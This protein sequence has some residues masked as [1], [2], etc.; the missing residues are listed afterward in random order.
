MLR[1]LTWLKVLGSFRPVDLKSAINILVS[2]IIDVALYPLYNQNMINVLG[3]MYFLKELGLYFYVR[4][5]TEDLY[6]I[7]PGRE[8]KIEHFI[9]RA[10]PE[11]GYFVD[12]GANIG[13]YTCL[14]GKV[15]N[16]AKVISV[17]PL[18][19]TFRVLKLNCHLN[20]IKAITI[21]KALWSKATKLS[22]CI[23]KV[24]GILFY[25]LSRAG[26]KDI[27]T[28][29]SSIEIAATT[30]DSV[31]E[32]YPFPRVDLIKID[33]EGSEYEML[34]GAKRTI[35]KT[36]YLYIECRKGLEA[37][38][39]NYLKKYGFVFARWEVPH[40]VHLFCVNVQV[41]NLK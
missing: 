15:K 19:D 6:Y 7:I 2:S 37:L 30:L 12:V 1:A 13:Y 27:N 25:G 39:K 17:E 40:A 28:C 31:L 18:P 33:A 41:T 22:F 10:V 23:P 32:I 14:I 21:N 35:R 38:I 24:K 26:S 34:L 36:R 11:G 9:L 5:R 20:H 8:G 16:N 4:P 3:G 29:L